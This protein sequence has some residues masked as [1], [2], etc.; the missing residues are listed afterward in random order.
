M[1]YEINISENGRHLFATAKHSITDEKKLKIVYDKLSTAFPVPQYL[2]T[3]LR[4][5]ITGV[6]VEGY[7]NIFQK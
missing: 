2:I 1:Y 7:P 4:Y 6:A 3:V 5:E